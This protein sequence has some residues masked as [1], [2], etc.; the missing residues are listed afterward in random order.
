MLFI[1]QNWLL[2]A[3]IAPCLWA[4]VAIIDT[5]FVHGVYEDE[6]DGAVISGV[7]QLLPWLLV[8][9]G[10]IEFAFPGA[11]IAVLALSAGGFFLFSFFYYFKALFVSNDTALMLTFWNVSVLVVPFFAWLLIGEVLTSAHYA[12][13]GIA[14]LGIILLNFDGKV[15]GVGFMKIALPMFGAVV[16]LSFSMVVA[17]M[18]YE[19]TSDFWSVFLLFSLGAAIAAFVILTIGKK[20]PVQR[21]R[22][23][24]KL[25]RKHF[26]FFTTAEG[27]SIVATLT[28][29]K[30][31][32]IAPSVSF[33]AVVESLVP[34]FV[35]L[36]S[37]AIVFIFR[38]MKRIDVSSYRNQ[39]SGVGVKVLAL[40]FITVGI[41]MIS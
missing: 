3:L 1:T 2:V 34:V 30:A 35:M 19:L 23:I 32:S 36:I 8:P 25:S 6:Y 12:G 37:F 20:S 13:I 39:V 24:A 17:R 7:F 33:V 27:L 4:I 29:Q 38:N 40:A 18:V 22:K 16:F 5:H 9:L 14:F 21:A 41:Y 28:S 31:I 11:E 15:K 10:V 26:L